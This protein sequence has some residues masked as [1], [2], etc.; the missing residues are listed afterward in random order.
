[1]TKMNCL[2]E[3]KNEFHIKTLFHI[4]NDRHP[5]FYRKT[6][7]MLSGET[8]L[9]YSFV[10]GCWNFLLLFFLLQ[11]RE[12]KMKF[13][14]LL[15]LVFVGAS[16]EWKQDPIVSLTMHNY[17]TMFSFLLTPEQK[18]LYQTTTTWV[19]SFSST[20]SI[21]ILSVGFFMLPCLHI[22]AR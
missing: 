5:L 3:M 11:N 12:I 13:Y 21:I 1:M 9:K 17:S 19:F 7:S 6:R 20:I 8:K 22:A 15:I 10:A 14:Y 18:H 16:N 4:R 2:I